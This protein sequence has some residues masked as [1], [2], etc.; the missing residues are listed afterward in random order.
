M[1]L[2]NFGEDDYRGA[3][4]DGYTRAVKDISIAAMLIGAAVWLLMVVS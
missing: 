3:A 4:A 2:I 1:G